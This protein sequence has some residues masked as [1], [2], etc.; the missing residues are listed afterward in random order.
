M[1]IL[2]LLLFIPSLSFGSTHTP[3]LKGQVCT[4]N[5]LKHADPGCCKSALLDCEDL[6]VPNQSSTNKTRCCHARNPEN[7]DTNPL[8]T[9]RPTPL[10]LLSGS[11][12][13]TFPVKCEVTNSNKIQNNCELPTG[14][15]THNSTISSTTCADGATGTGCEYKCYGG[16]KKITNNCKAS[17]KSGTQG[18]G[19][20]VTARPHDVNGYNANTGWSGSCTGAGFTGSCRYYCNDGN[21]VKYSDS[22]AKKCPYKRQINNYRINGYCTLPVDSLHGTRTGTCESGIGTCRYTCYNGSWQWDYSSYNSCRTQTQ[23]FFWR[24]FGMPFLLIES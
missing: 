10:C 5:D 16:L 8:T 15:Y 19:C 21:W 20:T 24:E 11:S 18:F 1:K 2:I 13:D 14:T 12:C 6:V 7:W 9:N 4:K 17:C 3:A 22:C 23:C